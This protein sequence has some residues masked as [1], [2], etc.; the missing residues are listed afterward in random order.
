MKPE[1][2]ELEDPSE[3]LQEKADQARK[4]TKLENL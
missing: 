2:I 1:L 4:E 3:E